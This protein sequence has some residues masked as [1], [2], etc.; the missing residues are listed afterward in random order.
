MT[1]AVDSRLTNY[2]D[3]RDRKLK[4]SLVYVNDRTNEEVTHDGVVESATPMGI[5]FRIKG[6]SVPDLILAENLHG[7]DVLK[8]KPTQYKSTRLDPSTEHNVRRHLADRHAFPLTVVNAMTDEEALLKH[9]EIEHSDLSH[10][11]AEKPKKVDRREQAIATAVAT[12]NIVEPPSIVPAPVDLGLGDTGD[13]EEE[14]D[15][16]L[17]E[18]EEDGDLEE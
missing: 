6:H 9:A 13:L 14:G 7:Y 8:E 18:E 4:V 16:D 1:T 15:G 10:F 17:E 5:L 11:H 3:A 12:V 2:V